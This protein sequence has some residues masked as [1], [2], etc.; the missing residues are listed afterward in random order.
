MVGQVSE[1]QPHIGLRRQP[2]AL[3]ADEGF[4]VGDQR[5]GALLADSAALVGG[6]ATD[7]LLDGVETGNALPLT[8]AKIASLSG[9][10]SQTTGSAS[11]SG[12][13]NLTRTLSLGDSG[14]DVSSLQQ[15]LKDQGFFSYPSL[16][17]YFGPVTQAAV[18]AFQS[19]HGIVS[20]GTPQTLMALPIVPLGE[21]ILLFAAGWVATGFRERPHSN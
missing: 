12:A 16:T 3:G 9:S 17:G 6:R 13:L 11:S 10:T 21:P 18:E 8:R 2:L 5:F 20:S 19:A 7:L 15:F 14:Q 1:R 4:K